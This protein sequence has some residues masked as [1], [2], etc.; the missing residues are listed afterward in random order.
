MI[1]KTRTRIGSAIVV[2]AVLLGGGFAMAVNGTSQP[3]NVNPTKV[4]VTLVTPI[5]EPP[6]SLEDQLVAAKAHVAATANDSGVIVCLTTVGTLAGDIMVDRPAGAK[7][8]TKE[9]KQFACEQGFKG[10]H[11][12]IE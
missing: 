2:S 9:E 4:P 8:F 6:Q 10:S 12:R 3:A 5:L 7:P 1:S 11:L